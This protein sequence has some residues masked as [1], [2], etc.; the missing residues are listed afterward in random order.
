MAPPREKLSFCSFLVF[1]GAANLLYLGF[2]V[3]VPYRYISSECKFLYF[4]FLSLNFLRHPFLKWWRDLY[5][6]VGRSQAG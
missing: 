4:G 6:K 2:R 5:A 3:Q 1:S